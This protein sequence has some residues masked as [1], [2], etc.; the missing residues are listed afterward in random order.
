[1]FIFITAGLLLLTAIV[2][3]V[4]RFT[5]PDFR[6]AWLIAAG[7]GLLAWISVFIWQTGIPAI[8]QFPLW[9]PEALFRQSPLFVVDGIA[10]TFALSLTTLCLAVIVTAVARPNFPYSLSWI[11]ILI[12]TALGVLAVTADNPLTLVLLWAAIDLGELVAQLRLVEGPKMSERVVIAFG[13]RA[14]GILILLWANMVSASNGFEMDFLSAPPQAGLYLILAAGLRLGVLPLHLPYASESSIRRGF[15]TGLRMVSAG[16]SLVLLA[17]IPSG[18][19]ESPLTPFL[20]IFVSFAAL[21]AGWMWLRS[22]DELSGRPYWVLGFGSL[23]VSAALRANPIGAT[24]WSSALILSGG[25]LFLASA[26]NKWVSRALYFGAWGISALPFSLTATGW[27]NE[28]QSLWFAIPLLLLAQAMLVAGFIRQNQ[29]ASRATFEDQPI[30]A[31]NVYPIG[32]AFL[33]MT[34]FILGFFGWDGTLKLGNW[35]AAL[36]ASLLTFGL[37]WLTPRL[38]LLNPVR[39][40]WVRPSTSSWL[41][42]SYRSLWDLYRAL[43]RISNTFSNVIEGESGVMWTLLFL[44]LFITIF[45]QR[46][47]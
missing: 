26:Q 8:V 6:Y 37:L 31:K 28:R 42:L 20:T 16:S 47:P 2:L 29:R 11:G 18:S 30:W 34:I 44:A 15:G 38:R 14:T 36:I 13:S 10:W 21:Y 40:H 9:Q 45:I 22:P 27:V 4:L 41:D 7:G 32:I 19:V 33:L 1:M 46:T 25:A 35:L 5:S 3:L 24:A 43:G 12:L 17:R 39:A 23:A